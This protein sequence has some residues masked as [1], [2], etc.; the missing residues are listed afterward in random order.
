MNITSMDMNSLFHTLF[1]KAP[2]KPIM[3]A[4]KDAADGK[5]AEQNT[6]SGSGWNKLNENLNEMLGE[7]V[8][9]SKAVNPEGVKDLTIDSDISIITTT[10]RFESSGSIVSAGSQSA[11]GTKTADRFEYSNEITVEADSVERLLDYDTRLDSNIRGSM[12]RA[13]LATYFGEIA[14]RL[15]TAFSEGKF[16]Q[17]EYDELN[18]GLMESYDKYIS[19]CEYAAASQQVG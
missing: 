15:D 17:E 13:Q 4:I 14:E 6:S 19:K 9:F 12:T 1:G 11:G 2:K 8:D 3:D 10:D 18:A 16:T 7:R 5:S